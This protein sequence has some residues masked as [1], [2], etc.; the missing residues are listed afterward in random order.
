MWQMC[1]I[2]LTTYQMLRNVRKNEKSH[3]NIRFAI[4]YLIWTCHYVINTISWRYSREMNYDVMVTSS[5][6]KWR[7]QS[8]NDAIEDPRLNICSG[9]GCNHWFGSDMHGLLVAR[10]F[11]F[12]RILSGLIS[13][14]FWIIQKFLDFF[15]EILSDWNGC[16]MVMLK[17]VSNG[18]ENGSKRAKWFFPE[19]VMFLE[20]STVEIFGAVVEQLP[21]K[22]ILIPNRWP[23][24]TAKGQIQNLNIFLRHMD[25]QF[26]EPEMIFWHDSRNTIPVWTNMR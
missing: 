21:V 9:V 23:S 11:L 8:N 24:V 22:S 5:V 4:Y 3:W 25:S 19:L 18:P 1:Q 26:I 12:Y 6:L 7:H 15:F 17:L 2:H 14:K 10:R 13:P 16:G 20:L